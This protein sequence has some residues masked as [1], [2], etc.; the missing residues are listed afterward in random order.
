MSGSTT[1]FLR[2]KRAWRTT[3]A[4]LFGALAV[5]MRK[6]PDY[7]PFAE[8]V[9]ALTMVFLGLA[10]ADAKMLNE[11]VRGE[12]PTEPLVQPEPMVPEPVDRP[13]GPSQQ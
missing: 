13:N 8:V 3:A 10:A 7:A 2:K 6:F 5:L 4:G 12:A 1:M 11:R 9:E